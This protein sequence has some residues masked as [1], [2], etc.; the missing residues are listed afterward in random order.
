MNIASIPLLQEQTP[1]A[2]AIDARVDLRVGAIAAGVM[3]PR[4]P[5]EEAFTFSN[6]AR[7][8]RGARMAWLRRG[9]RT[10]LTLAVPAETQNTLDADLLSDAAIE[11]GCTRGAVNFQLH[12]REIVAGGAALAEG[13]RARRWS[14]V[15]RGD[16]ACPL[17]F[18]AHA[19]EFYAELVV[20][21]PE[22][23]DP[24]FALE[25]GDGTP[26]GRR[27]IAA[28]AAGIILTAD[29]VTNAAQARMLAIA[30][31]RRGGGPHAEA[32]FAELDRGRPARMTR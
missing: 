1:L 3:H 24:F 13:L 17:Q 8:L 30:D 25:D 21:V 6:L 19:R 2:F 20:D 23:L 18:D 4:G 16:P 10:T 28:K 14:I 32:R 7:T 9:L 26:L 12:E 5:A 29:T 31:F 11:A 27:L 22:T 15:L